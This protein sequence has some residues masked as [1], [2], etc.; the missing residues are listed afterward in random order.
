MHVLLTGASGQV[1]RFIGAALKERGNTLTVLGRQA[2]N[3]PHD[4]AIDWDLA[5]DRV[6]LPHADALVHCALS[7]VPGKYRGGEGADPE[8]FVRLNV[9]GTRTLFEAAKASGIPHTV[10]LS[11]R[12]VYRDTA[13]W[14]VLTEHAPAVPDT[15]YGEVK[16]AGETMLESLCDDRFRGTVLRATGVYGLPPGLDRHKWSQLFERFARGET[17]E[18]RV[19][20][21]VYGGD[22]ADAVD[23][24]LEKRPA[25]GPA[26]DV[27][28]LSDL[29]LDRQDLL[30]IYA[31]AAAIP[32]PLPSRGAG[33][34]GVME[35]GK[36]NALGWAPG[37]KAF[38][39]AFVQSVAHLQ[40]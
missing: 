5:R 3:I 17:I 31:Y 12:A 16:R 29:L 35:P 26:F 9:G 19:S 28:N 39:E 11:S 34:V 36:L 15:L 30:K 32:L 14:A 1:G 13:K 21:E 7:H 25:T 2:P 37:G 20:T 22:L 38:L 4:A 23:L 40:C 24:V 33:P 8:A 6:D 10:F 18:P 27:F